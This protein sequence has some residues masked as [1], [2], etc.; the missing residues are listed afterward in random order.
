MYKKYEGLILEDTEDNG[1]QKGNSG[2]NEDSWLRQTKVETHFA[3]GMVENYRLSR[4]GK[5]LDVFVSVVG[6][7]VVVAFLILVP[8][9]YTHAISLPQF[10]K[11]LLVAPPPPPP[12]PPPVVQVRARIPKS[13]FTQGKLFEPKFIPKKIE[14]VKEEEQPAP[15]IGGQIGG[16]IGGVPGGQL[17]GV[18]GGVL[19]GMRKLP[20]PP[21]PTPA[22]HKGPYRVGGVVQPPKLIHQVQ[23]VYPMLAKE[24]RIQG[25]VVIDSVIDKQGD[26]TQMKVVSGSP[27][28]IQAAMQSLEQWKYQPT[29]LNGEPVDVDMLVTVH[30]Q[31]GS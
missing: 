17:G 4:Q 21:R 12:P 20:A 26:V 6:H 16:V 18:L 1:A 31:M 3:D 7:T 15:A 13:F 19:G 9:L 14:Q 2:A 30:F 5:V 10:E 25:D 28:L 23:P 8:L 22:V 24:A 27:L 11:T 29:L